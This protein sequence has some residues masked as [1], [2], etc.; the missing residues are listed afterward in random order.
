MTSPA[1]GGL[2]VTAIGG[3]EG[4]AAIEPEWESLLAL[5]ASDTIFLAPDWIQSWWAAYGAGRDLVAL[6]IDDASGLIGLALMYRR[7]EQIIQGLRQ[8]ALAFVGDGSADSDYMDWISARGREPEVVHALIDHLTRTPKW[9]LLALREIP[10]TSPHLGPI[11]A[12]ARERG[13]SWIIEQ[14]PCARVSLPRS[15]DD[16]LRMLKP[17][18]RTKVRSGLRDFEGR[19]DARFD[20]CTTLD[21]LEPRLASLYELHNRRWERE[22]KR[23]IFHADDKR[24]FYELLSPRLLER[25][26]LRLYSLS[27]DGR[28]VAHQYCFEYAN[29]LYLLN[30]GLDPE[31]FEHGAG[32]ALRAYAFRDCIARGLDVYDFLGGVTQHK[33]SWGAEVVHS[34]R[35]ITGPP[36]IRNRIA[37]TARDAREAAKRLFRPDREAKAE[38][39]A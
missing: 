27:V 32:N 18:M 26:R 15:W 33:L 31:W 9:D 38:E 7:E 14:V 30:E 13:W 36:S 22:G 24:A 17:R 8:P 11:E 34:V 1:T 35:V 21:D 2:R 19:A 23:G 3:K 39:P 20:C 12:V 29:R 5:S 16:Y 28:Y 25:D 37:F 4:L 6:R 10:E